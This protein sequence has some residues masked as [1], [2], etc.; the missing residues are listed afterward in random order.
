MFVKASISS[1]VLALFF[2]IIMEEDYKKKYEEALERAKVINSGTNNYNIVTEIFPELK[3][4]EDERIRKEIICYLD[5]EITLSNFGGDIA[6]FKKWIA[7]LEKQ[8]PKK[9]EEELEKAYKCADEVQ[10]RKGYEDAKRE[11]ENQ[12]EQ[13]P[14]DKVEPKFKVGDWCIDEEDGTIFQIIKVLDNTYTYKTNEGYEY[15]CTHYSLENDAKLWTIQDAKE[16]DVLVNEN[17]IPFIFNGFLEKITVGAHCGITGGIFC[18]PREKNIW[19]TQNVLPATKEQRDLL[20]QKIKEA[21]YEWNAEKK[22]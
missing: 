12:N 14:T 2:F 19:A 9:H 17:G 4:S 10:Y 6:T 8:D 5:R 22:N 15:S 11:I 18:I 20:F 1:E 3:E 21:G 16:G 7:W 13:K